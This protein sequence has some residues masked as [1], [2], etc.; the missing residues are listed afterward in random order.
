LASLA[1]EHYAHTPPRLPTIYFLK[2]TSEL[3]KVWQWL[4]VVAFP[5]SRHICILW[6]QLR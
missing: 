5:V 4:C 1:M 6:Q 2:L 3:H